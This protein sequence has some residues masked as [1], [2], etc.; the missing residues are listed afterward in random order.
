MYL[1]SPSETLNSDGR[2]LSRRF[3]RWYGSP[4]DGRERHDPQEEHRIPQIIRA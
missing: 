4:E 1:M 3:L 2:N